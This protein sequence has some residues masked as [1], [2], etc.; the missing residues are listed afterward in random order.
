V[1]ASTQEEVTHNMAWLIIGGDGQLGLSF[2]NLLTERNI[3]F[4]FSTIDTL[5]ITNHKD[6]H[7][8]VARRKPSVVVNCAAWT[9]VDAAEDNE[10][11]A[12]AVNC[13]GARHVAQAA[14]LVGATHVLVSTDYVFPGNATSP[15]KEDDLTGPASVYGKSKLCGEQAALS[16]YS[17]HTYVVR[18]A[19]LYSK[20]GHNFVKTMTRKALAN[21]SVRVVDDQLG[22]P[23]HAGDL[24][25][26]IFEIVKAKAP[27]GIYHGTNSGQTSWHELTQSIYQLLGK[28]V[29][30]V[31]PVPSTEYPTKAVRPSFSVLDHR[32]TISNKIPE[33]R[34][35]TDA[36]RHNMDD[37]RKA[38]ESES[39]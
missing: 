21:D 22:Q 9:A 3:P 2:R 36:L 27:T 25:E 16:E 14:K 1:V 38:I 5:D 17:S 8:F 33:M 10:S 20:Y 12:F 15:Y 13:D 26:H 30:L 7:A 32:K 23:T 11:A 31:S 18:T 4:D 28:S 19:W 6:V 39:S 24:A 34:P 37:I 29:D 35:W